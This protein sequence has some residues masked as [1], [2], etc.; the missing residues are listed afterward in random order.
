MR[1]FLY[2]GWGFLQG[3]GVDPGGMG[4]VREGRGW[5]GAGG[6][7]RGKGLGPIEITLFRVPFFRFY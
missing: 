1:V 6:R 3:D 2:G 7:G 5:D 4:G